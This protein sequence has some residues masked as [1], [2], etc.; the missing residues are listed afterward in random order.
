MNSNWSY[1]PETLNSGQNHRLILSRV[2]LKFVG[3]PWK[4]VGHLF[5]ATLSFLHHFKAIGEFRPDLQSGNAQ[6]GSKSGIFCPVW[7]W[8]NRAPLPSCL[9]LCASF[10]SHRWVQTKVTVWKL[11]IRVKMGDYL[12]RVTF[13]FHGWPWYQDSWGQHGAHLGPKET[14]WAPC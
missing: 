8:N 5:Y 3:G 1:C 2:T 14:R 7:P 4:T 13:E 10:H 6:F 11:S 9:K 12:S